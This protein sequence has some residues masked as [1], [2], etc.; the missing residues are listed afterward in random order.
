MRS[1][2]L[3]SHIHCEKCDSSDAATLYENTQDKS[4]YKKCFSCDRTYR[5]REGV[6]MEETK[7]VQT[8]NVVIGDFKPFEANHRALKKD[9]LNFYGVGISKEG[10]VSFPYYSYEN[11]P[12]AEKIRYL[13]KSFSVKH[14][15]PGGFQASGLFGANKFPRGGK[16]ITVT[17]GEYDAIS[18][19]EMMGSKYACVSLRNGASARI[20]QEDKDYLDSFESVIYCGDMDEPGRKAA[21]KFASLFDKS[22][23]K[24]TNLSRGKDSNEYLAQISSLE[25]QGK[26]IEASELLKV[27]TREWWNSSPYT[28]EGLIQGQATLDLLINET[29]T[30]S[31]PY[32]WQGLDDLLH[33]VR[34]SE[35]IVFTAGSGVGKTAVLRELAYHLF[36]NVPESKIGCMFLEESV[37]RTVKDLVSLELNTN[38]RLPENVVEPEKKREAWA[39]LF[40][41]DRWIF[42]DHFGSNDVDTVCSQVRF[43]ANNFGAKYI[44][45]DHISIIVSDGSSGDE[46]KALDSIM[47]KLRTLVQELD[48]CLFLV[49]HLRRSNDSVSHEEGGVTSLSQLRGSAGIGQL[50]DIVVGLERN[51]QAE[52]MV[53]RNVTT[54]RIL[55]NRYTGET[56]PACYLVWDKPTSRLKAYTYQEIQKLITEEDAR[57]NK[58]LESSEEV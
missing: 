25:G 5:V 35:L 55:K 56:G 27:F 8:N 53:E 58:D 31:V 22:K 10:L 12:V 39:T 3:K 9:S 7:E 32:P 19:Y 18:C 40:D 20:T 52:N 11:K 29:E 2:A 16:F 23:V 36:K 47:T 38:L 30:P 26:F 4:Q 54:L 45:L 50:A 14:T 24:I 28:P 48:I 46:R 15:G 13:D 6:Q 51:G 44:F 33:G 43:I 37:K 41:N 49:S 42:W 21:Q 57:F 34:T 17:E 1:V